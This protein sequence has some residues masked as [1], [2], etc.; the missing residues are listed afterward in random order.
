MLPGDNRSGA[1][2][3]QKKRDGTFDVESWDLAVTSEN[4]P[5][6]QTWSEEANS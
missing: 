2:K 5:R 6:R 1:N 4:R 3:Y